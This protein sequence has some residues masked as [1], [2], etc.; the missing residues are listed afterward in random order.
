MILENGN[1]KIFDYDPIK[2]KEERIQRILR[3]MKN[4]LSQ[5]ENL[6][7]Y[8]SES[9]PGKF[10]GTAKVHKTSKN[11]TV[12]ELPYGQLFLRFCLHL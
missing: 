3:K 2:K 5:Q 12:D 9:W 1:F 10:Y 11:D 6:S 8:A 4:R 7:L